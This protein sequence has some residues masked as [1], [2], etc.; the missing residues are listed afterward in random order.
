MRKRISKL[1]VGALLV[2]SLMGFAGCGN[3]DNAGK[4]EEDANAV[5]TE[6]TATSD[7]GADNA[8]KKDLKVGAV[9]LGLLRKPVES[10]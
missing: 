7:D 9:M 4:S 5:A 3:S 2:T 8:D 10:K 6:E 1:L